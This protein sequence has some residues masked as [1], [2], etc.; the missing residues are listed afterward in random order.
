MDD[1]KVVEAIHLSPNEYTQGE[2]GG[3]ELN[4]MK[5]SG[6]NFESK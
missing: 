5:F 1:L 2:C 4:M 3:M 6:E